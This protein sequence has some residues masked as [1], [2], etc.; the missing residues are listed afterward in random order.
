MPLED[1]IV[2]FDDGAH[3]TAL[4]KALLSTLPPA[5]RRRYL[6]DSG[7]RRVT[8]APG[9]PAVCPAFLTACPILPVHAGELQ[10]AAL[11]AAAEE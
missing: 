6:R 1:L 11:G 5:R 8:S 4:G 9:A 2:G 3:A 7:L 10:C